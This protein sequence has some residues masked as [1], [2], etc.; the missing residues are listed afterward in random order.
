MQMMQQI[1]SECEF[2]RHHDLRHLLQLRDEVE[3]ARHQLDGVGPPDGGAEVAVEHLAEEL[4]V[5]AA[6][7][8]IAQLG[9]QGAAVREERNHCH[10]GHRDL[11]EKCN[12]F[13]VCLFGRQYAT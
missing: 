7:V 9:R 5:L 2:L 13:V 6:A 8:A 4:L 1:R 11:K 10:Q 12:L 3:V